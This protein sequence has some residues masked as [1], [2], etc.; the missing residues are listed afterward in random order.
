MKY[1]LIARFVLAMA[2]IAMCI[3]LL[4]NIN[5][6]YAYNRN[7]DYR[8]IEDF[9][10][11]LDKSVPELQKRYGVEGTAIGIIQDGKV[12]Y[13]LNYGLADKKKNN[14][15]SDDTIFQ[16]ASISKSLTAWGIMKL[17]DEGKISLD[18]PVEKYLTRWHLPDSEF[19]RDEITI[20]RLLSHTAGLNVHGYLGVEPGRKMPS[21]EES[22]SGAGL[23]IKPLKIAMEPGKKFSYSGGGYTL[24]QLVIEEVTG[25]AFEQYMDEEILKPLQMENSSYRENYENINM[26]KGY[27]YFGQEIPNYNF[28]EKAAAGLKTTVPDIMKFILASMDGADGETRGR[29]ILKSETLDLIHKSVLINS[30]L[31][32]FTDT[33]PDGTK[34]LYHGGDNRGWHG[35]YG[36]IPQKKD[37]IVIFMNS[38]NG[39]DL[40]EELFYYWI[41]HECGVM[42]DKYYAMEKSR[43]VNLIIAAGLGAILAAYVLL[44]AIS[45]RRGRRVFFLGKKEKSFVKLFLRLLIP[46][47]L[48]VLI[49]LTSYKL[50][51]LPLQGGVKYIAYVVFAWMVVLLITGFFP[52]NKRIN[53]RINKRVLKHNDI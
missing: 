11:K 19:K 43:N 32:V 37:G 50:S 1:R 51:I 27:G 30:G 24:L 10:N 48:A 26:S 21:I 3:N 46:L 44:F 52:R 42:P 5:A 22:L 23:F 18:D 35:I 39:M 33:L 29:N 13:I 31:G 15:I 25:K 53:K 4:S 34:L 49:Y 8:S 16:A 38:E 7:P 6:V 9:K 41:Q 40:R 47:A 2:G 36:F 14:A 12:K 28:T 17:V 45:L 20:R